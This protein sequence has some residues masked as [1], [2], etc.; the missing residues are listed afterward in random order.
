[1]AKYFNKNLRYIR[2]LFNVSQQT[3]ADELKVDR[4]SISRWEKGEIDTPLDAALK[5]AEYFKIKYEYFFATNLIGKTK[6]EIS[7]FYFKIKKDK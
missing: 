4:S 3:L 2:N 6:E 5:I 7:E 1:M